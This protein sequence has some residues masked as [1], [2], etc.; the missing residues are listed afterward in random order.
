[1]LFTASASSYSLY[2]NGDLSHAP[3]F[4]YRCYYVYFKI[5]KLK[6]G[7]I[8][9]K[10]FDVRWQIIISALP[11]APLQVIAF[12]RIG[13]ML[14]GIAITLPLN[15]VFLILLPLYILVS[16]FG[17]SY[18]DLDYGGRPYV[19]LLKIS[20]IGIPAMLIPVYLT[21]RWTLQYNENAQKGQNIPFIGRIT[22][23]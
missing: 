22:R 13:K 6:T 16:V 9:N 19:D 8:T 23:L 3:I 11:F 5:K 21:K 17:F 20:S 7:V 10:P 1:M 2:S 14:K 12:S 4:N 15:I 18:Y